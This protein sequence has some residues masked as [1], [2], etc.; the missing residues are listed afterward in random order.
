MENSFHAVWLSQS[1]KVAYVFA[2]LVAIAT[3]GKPVLTLPAPQVGFYKITVTLSQKHKE[4]TGALKPKGLASATVYLRLLYKIG[5]EVKDFS[6]A[7]ILNKPKNKKD[8]SKDDSGIFKGDF[9]ASKK[10]FIFPVLGECSDKGGVCEDPTHLLWGIDTNVG[11]FYD[12]VDVVTPTGN[13][14]TFNSRSIADC[15]SVIAKCSGANRVW[16]L[17]SKEDTEGT[18]F[19]LNVEA[20]RV[21]NELNGKSLKTP[22]A[23]TKCNETMH[24]ENKEMCST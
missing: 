15:G 5:D 8:K 12:Q 18:V 20:G 16:I 14:I 21:F 13:L 2:I 23:S 9:A 4:T 24:T 17:A 22:P 11:F 3:A 6:P 10:S 19:T 7:F 1:M